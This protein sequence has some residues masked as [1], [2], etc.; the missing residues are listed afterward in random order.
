MV[1]SS[2]MYE[3]LLDAVE[4]L[5]EEFLIQPQQPPGVP[6]SFVVWELLRG[7]HYDHYRLH[8]V[9]IRAWLDKRVS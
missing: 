3:K 1:E 5:P 8:M 9:D 7:N 6:Q 4:A 2:Q